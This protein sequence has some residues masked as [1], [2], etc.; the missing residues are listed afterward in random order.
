MYINFAQTITR[1]VL[2]LFSF[3]VVQALKMCGNFGCWVNGND[4]IEATQIVTNINTLSI[5]LVHQRL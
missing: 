3:D 1:S 4:I 5:E 2:T